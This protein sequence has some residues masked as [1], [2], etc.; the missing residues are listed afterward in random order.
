MNWFQWL[1]LAVGIA[2]T[3]FSGLRWHNE[4]KLTKR[5]CEN[6]PSQ[7]GKTDHHAG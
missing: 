1:Q 3:V 4:R 6:P 5:K 7:S 2:N